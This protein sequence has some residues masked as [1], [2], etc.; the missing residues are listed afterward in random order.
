M[1]KL[2]LTKKAKKVL[3]HLNSV[4]FDLEFGCCCYCCLAEYN[5]FE[6]YFPTFDNFVGL[7]GID[8]LVGLGFE[9]TADFVLVGFVY[10]VSIVYIVDLDCL[11][12]EG[13]IGFV[14]ADLVCIGYLIGPGFEGIA[15]F[16]LAGFVDF[17]SIADIVDL[18]VVDF[19]DIDTAA[20][21][22]V[23]VVIVIVAVVAVVI[24]VVIVIATVVVVVEYFA[25]FVDLEDIAEA[26]FENSGIETDFVKMLN[27]LNNDFA[28]GNSDFAEIVNSENKIA[29]LVDM[30]NLGGIEDIEKLDLFV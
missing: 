18:V 28:V 29:D 4:D 11:D 20:V 17:V 15:D 25:D 3:V 14:E 12:F 8:Y 16:V 9:G 7:A 22:V 21:V 26:Y 19:V 1:M 27:L 23:A 24:A 2:L 6:Y 30:L 10:F 13:K 5:Y